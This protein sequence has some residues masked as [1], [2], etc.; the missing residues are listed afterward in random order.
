[1]V[2]FACRETQ[3]YAGRVKYAGLE[4]GTSTGRWARALNFGEFS[5]LKS[6]KKHQKIIGSIFL[7]MRVTIP[8]TP[9][10]CYS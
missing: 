4:T 6:I 1:V 9:G 3:T 8:G 5:G 7:H 10:R 2:H